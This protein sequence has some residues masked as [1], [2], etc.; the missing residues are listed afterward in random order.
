MHQLIVSQITDNLSIGLDDGRK[1]YRNHHA[2]DPVLSDRSKMNLK[3]SNLSGEAHW[4]SGTRKHIID[5]RARFSVTKTMPANPFESTF[6][7][8]TS[9][10]GIL[11]VRDLTMWLFV[12]NLPSI[13]VREWCAIAQCCTCLG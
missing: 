6:L 5:G 8:R 12:L 7:N 3:C 4:A 9:G 11:E 10:P 2:S 13:T 1:L